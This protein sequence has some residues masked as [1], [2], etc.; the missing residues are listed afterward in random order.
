[1]Q[2]IG[3]RKIFWDK[4]ARGYARKPIKDEASYRRTMERTIAHLSAEDTVLEVGCGTGS[5]ALLLAPK[6]AHIT[7]T[8]LSS[9]MI[10][11]AKERQREA[12]VRN[13][14]FLRASPSDDTLPSGPFDAV[15]A[16]NFLHLADDPP[17]TVGRLANLLKPGGR[18]ITKTPC[19]GSRRWF[20][21]PVIG[22]MRLVGK[23][24]PVEF[25][26]AAE[27]E[28]VIVATGLEIVETGDYPAPSRFIV[29]RRP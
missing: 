9:E 16:F 12:G 2:A 19:L 25:F 28:R 20:L 14:A 10:A 4:A 22:A 27:L 24:P 7:A 18:M 26:S 1:M 11:I 8:D 21:K 15:L 5:T 6:V 13:A 29:A 17:A 3:D 23:A